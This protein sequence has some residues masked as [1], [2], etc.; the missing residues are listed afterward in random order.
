MVRSSSRI[1]ANAA[2]AT[3][4]LKTASNIFEIYFEKDYE[5]TDEEDCEEKDYKEETYFSKYYCS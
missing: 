2:K 4:A 5:E 1:K 3:K